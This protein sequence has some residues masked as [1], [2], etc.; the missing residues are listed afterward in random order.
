MLGMI[1]SEAARCGEIVKH[2]LQFS[3]PSR[4]RAES[5]DV[6]ELVRGSVRL[7][8]H[9]IDLKGLESEIQLDA[10]APVVVCD[11]QQIRQALVAI[12]INACEA[13]SGEGKL[14]VATRSMPDGG[15]TLSIRDTGVGI[16]PET[17]KH[18]FEPFYTTKEQG[19]GLGLAVVYGIIRGHGGRIE[20]EST[21][22]EFTLFRLYLP[23]VP[24][25]RGAEPEGAA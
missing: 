3:R 18:L 22:G 1:E 20:V 19:G 2:L 24:P 7:V 23:P 15:V 5:C 10:A 13:M 17:R 11:P 4:P 14:S 16:D 8:Q 21:P 9:Q 12:L 25:E 6:N